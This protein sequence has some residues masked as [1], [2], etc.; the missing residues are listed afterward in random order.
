MQA[1]STPFNLS[2]ASDLGILPIAQW[3]AGVTDLLDCLNPWLEQGWQT[4]LVAGSGEPV[5][6]PAAVSGG[7]HQIVFA[8]GYFNSALHEAAHWCLAGARRRLREDYGY[9]YCPD[10]RDAGQQ[11]AFE[12]VEVKPQAI[13]WWLAS[14]TGR[15]F[16]T[17]TDNL[18]GTPTDNRPFRRAV[19]LQ[20]QRYL[21]DALPQRAQVA[22]QRLCEQFNRPWPDARCFTEL[23]R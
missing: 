20:A 22:V 12:Q 2:V 16:R 4:Q 6:L 7:L 14:A 17:S 9:W 13:E 8:H 5:Y 11:A 21:A 19:Q 3:E 18:N 15:P 10:G 1:V 23:P